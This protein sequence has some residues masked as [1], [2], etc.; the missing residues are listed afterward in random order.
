M[1]FENE[2]ILIKKKLL[3]QRLQKTLTRKK[4]HRDPTF[5]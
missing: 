1:A 2:S 4:N 5:D 3:S